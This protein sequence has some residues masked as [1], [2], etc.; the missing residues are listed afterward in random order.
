MSRCNSQAT[1]VFFKSYYICCEIYTGLLKD[2]YKDQPEMPLLPCGTCGQQYSQAS[3]YHIEPNL[4]EVL[5]EAKQIQI[6]QHSI[7]DWTLWLTGHMNKST[8]GHDT[9]FRIKLINNFNCCLQ[10]YQHENYVTVMALFC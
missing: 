3:L 7:I 1:S 8:L 9:K 6:I 10:L 4:F 2:D 5:T